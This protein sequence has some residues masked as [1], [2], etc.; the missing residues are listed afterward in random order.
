MNEIDKGHAERKTPPVIEGIEVAPVVDGTTSADAFTE[1]LR[2]FY[3]GKQ[4]EYGW[5]SLC[6]MTVPAGL[7][8][9]TT[10]DIGCRRGRGVYKLSERVG[11]SGRAI[12]LDWGRAYIEEAAEWSAHAAFKSGL[13][14]NNMAFAVGFP[15]NL[16]AC[17][18]G[19]GSVDMV[20][21][22]SV[23]NLAFDRARCLAEIFRV[24]K[25][26]GSLVCETVTADRVRDEGVMA[27]A[28][29]IGNSIQAA[30]SREVFL[31]EL[32]ECGFGRVESLESLEVAVDAGF[33]PGYSVETVESDEHVTYRAEVFQAFK[34]E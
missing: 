5:A 3:G 4:F 22:N 27:K 2:V 34:G 16:A 33:K 6:K 9:K 23:V 10:L 20:W 29:A 26:G 12:G 25:P 30:P 17:G 31:A 14:S 13:S 1:Q 19:D 7:E 32:C 11:E 8:G 24:L 18:I 21:V 28:K 15:E